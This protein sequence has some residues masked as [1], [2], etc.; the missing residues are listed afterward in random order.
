MKK[1]WVETSGHI[2]SG[3]YQIFSKEY[4]QY[5]PELIFGESRTSSNFDINEKRIVGGKN[6]MGAKVC[7]IFSEYFEVSGV[8]I[9]ISGFGFGWS[10][11]MKDSSAFI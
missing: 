2:V 3:T 11:F 1:K 5:A 8:D 6:G 10:F 7:N 9:F 4:G